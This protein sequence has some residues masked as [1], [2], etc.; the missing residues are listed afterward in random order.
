MPRRECILYITDDCTLCDEAL[1]M[2]LEST[3]LRGVIVTTVDV[4]TDDEL[5]RRFGE[6]IPV[7]EYI[8]NTLAWP[9][10]AEEAKQLLS[11][12]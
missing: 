10:S 6:H 5:F 11:T 2:L 9:F 4:A 8:G 12:T 3:T 7:L 1:R